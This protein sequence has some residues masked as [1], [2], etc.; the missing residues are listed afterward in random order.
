MGI[1]ISVLF[2]SCQLL[3]NP[4]HA[5]KFN[6][7]EYFAN[8]MTDEFFLHRSF[9]NHK[10]FKEKKMDP[11]RLEKIVLNL[12]QVERS[13]KLGRHLVAARNLRKGDEIFHEDPLAIGP[14]L[15]GALPWSC[16]GCCSVLF[17]EF[18]FTCPACHWPVCSSSCAGLSDPD[19]HGSECDLLRIVKEATKTVRMDLLMPLR[20]LLLQSTH[21][22]KWKQLLEVARR[23]SADHVNR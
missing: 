7:K 12:F 11:K 10:S 16:V 22:E 4:F 2:L 17:T 9:V 13:L 8:F 15:M 20:C 21:P 6:L 3:G 23:A 18:A 5:K 14:A 1:R 19:F